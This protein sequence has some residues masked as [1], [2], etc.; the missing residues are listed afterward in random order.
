LPASTPETS[1]AASPEAFANL[2]VESLQAN[3]DICVKDGAALSRS[4]KKRKRA[5]E[6]KVCSALAEI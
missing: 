6:V 4:Q 2:G 3:D 5:P 1:H